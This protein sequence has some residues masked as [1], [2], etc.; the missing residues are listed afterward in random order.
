[1]KRTYTDY[2][3]D[4]L[5]AAEKAEQFLSDVSEEQFKVN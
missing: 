2:L 3:R 1:M 4:I 5:D